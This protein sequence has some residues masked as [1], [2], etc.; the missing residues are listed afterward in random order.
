MK[1]QVLWQLKAGSVHRRRQTERVVF[2]AKLIGKSLLQVGTDVS[3]ILF[4]K[5][6]SAREK[7]VCNK[8]LVP[9]PAA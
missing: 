3:K 1:K 4:S 8:E 7:K 2:H 5:H 9:R 6:V